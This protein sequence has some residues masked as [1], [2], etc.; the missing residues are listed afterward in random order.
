MAHFA[1]TNENNIVDSVIV[2]E[3][4]VLVAEGGWYIKGELKPLNEW[5]QTSYNTKGGEYKIGKDKAEKDA[6]K[7]LGTEKDKKARDRKNFAG[8]GYIYDPVDDVFISPQPYPSWTLDKGTASYK[9][10]KKMPIDDKFYRWDE[11]LQDWVT[12]N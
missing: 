11:D 9:P 5:V 7:L 3:E 4:D 10:P 12:F 1:H 6:N 8:K 2:I